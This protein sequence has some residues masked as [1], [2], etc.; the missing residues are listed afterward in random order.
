MPNI[1]INYNLLGIA[2]LA[3]AIGGMIVAFFLKP[4]NGNG[5]GNGNAAADF[6]TRAARYSAVSEL[7]LTLVFPLSAVGIIIGIIVV[8]T[9]GKGEQHLAVLVAILPTLLTGTGRLL[10]ALKGKKLDEDGSTPAG[11]AGS[12][13]PS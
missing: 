5:N 2:L 10:A 1:T 8:I 6:G 3:L 4:K 13:V 11:N 9:T 7:T 12:S